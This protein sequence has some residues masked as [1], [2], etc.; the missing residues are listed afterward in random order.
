MKPDFLFD[1]AKHEY[2]RAGIVIPGCTRVIDHAGLSSLEDVRKDIL[3]RRSHLGRVVHKCA[4]FLDENDLDW[5]TVD[6][7]AKGYLE[8]WGLLVE[9]LHVKWRRIEFQCIA[10]VGGLEFGMQIDR[11]GLIYGCES[12]VDM[13]IS[14]TVEAWHG[15]QL[16]GYAMGLPHDLVQARLARVPPAPNATTSAFHEGRESQAHP[17]R[18]EAGLRRFQIRPG[19]LALEVT[20]RKENQAIGIGESGMS[21]QVATPTIHETIT[22]DTVRLAER[23]AP[24]LNLWRCHKQRVPSQSHL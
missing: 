23:V 13:K 12:I 15:V 5:K 24:T 11:E 2:S 9:D 3:E 22:V 17:V 4:H 21:T 19:R 6:D 1:E 8:S 7:S 10:N 20:H 14:R 16:A 18:L